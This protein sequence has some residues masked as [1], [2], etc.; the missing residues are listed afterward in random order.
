[1]VRMPPMADVSLPDMRA[2]S[3]PGTA[4]AAMMPMMATTIS[5]SISVNPSFFFSILTTLSLNAPGCLSPDHRQP[6]EEQGRCLLDHIDWHLSNSCCANDVEVTEA[7]DRLH[8]GAIARGAD[9]LWQRSLPMFF[10]ESK[11]RTRQRP[12]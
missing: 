8:E 7:T 5:S 11:A 1:M 4:I 3:R 12:A 9:K 2:R 10:S 6:A